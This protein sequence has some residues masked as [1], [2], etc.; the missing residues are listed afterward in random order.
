LS[1]RHIDDGPTLGKSENLFGWQDWLPTVRVQQPKETIRAE[2]TGSDICTAAGIKV[3]GS[4]PVLALCSE[5]LAAGV[6]PDAAIQVFRNATLALHI[7]R[8]GEAARL[9]INGR[10]TGFALK[11]RP[12]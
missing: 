1:N 6:N 8:I 9:E 10:G 11:E 12:S 2:L 5:L 3:R 7:R 4:T